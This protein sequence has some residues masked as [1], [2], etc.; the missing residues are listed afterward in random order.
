M[1]KCIKIIKEKSL[2]F[3][4]LIRNSKRKRV[5]FQ[6][7]LGQYSDNPRAISEAIHELDPTIDVVWY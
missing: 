1:N 2:K 3:L 4:Y 5:F 6:S 7:F